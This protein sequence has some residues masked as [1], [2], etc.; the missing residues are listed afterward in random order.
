MA[1]EETSVRGIRHGV[2]VACFRFEGSAAENAHLASKWQGKR[3]RY[4]EKGRYGR[5]GRG[6]RVFELEIGGLIMGI[7]VMGGSREADD[8]Y[9]PFALLRLRRPQGQPIVH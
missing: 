4:G 8:V 3:S 5:L 6:R 7:G 1:D 2:S 9:D